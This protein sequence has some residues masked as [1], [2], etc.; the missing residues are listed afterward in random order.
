MLVGIFIFFLLIYR[1]S[2]YEKITGHDYVVSIIG[3]D[4]AREFALWAFGD[5]YES[6]DLRD[7]PYR[8]NL[9]HSDKLVLFKEGD[10]KK[11]THEMMKIWERHVKGD[12]E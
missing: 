10:A 6:I 11:D 8:W 9:L 2:Y 7:V 1:F 4:A 12:W 3:E 5:D